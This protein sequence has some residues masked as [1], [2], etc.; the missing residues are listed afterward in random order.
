MLVT[1]KNMWTK[2]ND[3]MMMNNE[4]EWTCEKY[5]DAIEGL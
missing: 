1:L 5:L 2:T 4:N 3:E